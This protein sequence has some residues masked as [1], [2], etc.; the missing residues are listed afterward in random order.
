MKYLLLHGVLH[1]LGHDHERD[2]GEMNEIEVEV[3]GSVGLE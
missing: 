2:R 1:A 3:R